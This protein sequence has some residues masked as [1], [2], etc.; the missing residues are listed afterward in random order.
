MQ[1][2]TPRRHQRCL[3]LSALEKVAITATTINLA[4]KRVFSAHE[5]TRPTG[6]AGIAQA[7]VSIRRNKC[8]RIK[9]V[10]KHR[11]ACAN[12]VE[13]KTQGNMIMM[14]TNAHTCVV[15]GIKPTVSETFIK[16]H[17]NEIPSVRCNTYIRDAIPWIADKPALSQS[18]VSRAFRKAR[19]W[20]ANEDW[21]KEVQLG[22]AKIFQDHSVNVVLAEYGTTGAIL[23]PIC[24]ALETPLV[25]HFHGFD[26]SKY[27][28]LENNRSMYQDMFKI[29]AA[30]VVVSQKMQTMLEGL[31]CPSAKIVYNPY[32]VDAGLFAKTTRDTSISPPTFLSVGRFTGKKA[33]H[34]T[35]TA[36]K[37]VLS[38][39]PSAKL[40]MIGDGELLNSCKDLS[41]A[42]E[43]ESS[44]EF[45]GS[46]DHTQVAEEMSL[47]T[48]FVQ[49]SVRAQDG[50]MEGTPVAV[51]EAGQAGLPVVATNHAGIP[52]VVI[53][54]V[55]GLL[56]NEH[57]TKTMTEQMLTLA[58]DH[59]LVKKMGNA[60][61]SHIRKNFTMERSLG[62]LESVLQFAANKTPIS[63]F[64]PFEVLNPQ[65]ES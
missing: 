48:V 30:I 10:N 18:R 26:A 52:D 19:R 45:L 50:D 4:L 8:A 56:C 34:I 35:L 32:G 7:L 15:T 65:M 46:C 6:K 1:H 61:S 2:D 57:D 58:R 63:E 51:L 24:Q 60:A 17:I 20:V 49:H 39:C 16:A 28:V 21:S 42:L 25:V 41:R 64:E 38:A 11:T 12:I 44:V 47:A 9:S 59:N 40:R 54:G 62:L 27:D 53:D 36:F 3:N 23:A 33:P 22:Y 13:T 5:A 31:G 37:G 14:N 55:T 43:M 29:A